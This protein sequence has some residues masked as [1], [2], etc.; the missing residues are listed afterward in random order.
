M[1]TLTKITA[2]VVAISAM[3]TSIVTA[4]SAEEPTTIGPNIV[5]QWS[6]P[7]R[8]WDYL[9][10]HVIPAKPN[11]KGFDDVHMTDVPTVFQLPNGKKW[12]MTFI[13]FD[14]K[15]Y[16]SFV[17]ESD[18]LVHWT[19]IRLAM[20][21]GP[22]GSFDYGGV[23]LGAFL[24]E[25]YDIKAARTLK[26]R[27]GKY[28]SLYGAYPRQGGYELRPGYEGVASSDDGFTWQRAKDEPILS[29]HQE[30]CDTWEKDCIYQPWLV[31]HK[32]KFYNFYNAAN[33]GI[34]QMGLA[35]SNDILEW[36]RHA[37]NPVIPNGPEGSYNEKFSSDGKVFWDKDHW[38][39]FFFGVG[40]GGAHIMVAF[41]RDLYHWTVD[42]DPL[43]KSG[44]NL[45]GLDKKYA[46][47]IS[48]V[49]NRANETYYMF[50]NAVGNKGR[51]IGLIT[52]KPIERE[53][54]DKSNT[55]R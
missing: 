9:P 44:G 6:A 51:G 55:P 2:G 49:W 20:G 24:Y 25:D 31:E 46:H 18:D 29:V 8:G 3:L 33:G 14:G 53:G 12:Y 10:D 1:K 42:A 22:E 17:A 36:K 26:K 35:L 54:H 52:S 41:S 21:Y 32:G 40:R 48:L 47:K 5:K 4:R 43:Y 16:R 23:V 30:D 27:G 34:E 28:F 50:Y 15:G 7:Y 19:N 13:G 11:I 45:S 39:N 37:H 38:V